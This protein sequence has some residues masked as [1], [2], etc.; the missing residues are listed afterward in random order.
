MLKARKRQE[1]PVGVVRKEKAFEG[2]SMRLIDES[3]GRRMRWGIQVSWS[4]ELTSNDRQINYIKQSVPVARG[5]YC[6]DAKDYVFA[7]DLTSRRRRR[8][9]RVVYI[10]SG[11]LCNRLYAHLGEQ[12]N[13]CLAEHL[14]GYNLAYRFDRIVDD[15]LSLDWPRTVEAAMLRLFDGRFLSLPPANSRRETVADLDLDEF[16]IL[17]SDNFSIFSEG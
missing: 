2:L 1:V 11:W 5:V 9:S 12:R 8:W 3:T 6:I 13:A 7:A 10:G 17:E 4:R 15:D 14:T 16:G